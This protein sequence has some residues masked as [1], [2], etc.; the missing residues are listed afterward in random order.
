M[1]VICVKIPFTFVDIKVEVGEIFDAYTA[2]GYWYVKD[3]L[4]NVIP[5]DLTKPVSPGTNFI[6]L[7]EYR[8][9]QLDK[10]L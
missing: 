1:K 3:R 4:G 5:C 7:E 2:S 8:N 6:K 9:Q 10:I